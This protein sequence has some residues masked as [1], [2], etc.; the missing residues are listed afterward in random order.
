MRD[1]KQVPPIGKA[2]L[3]TIGESS[4]WLRATERQADTISL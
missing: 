2:H 3:T 4:T 1:I